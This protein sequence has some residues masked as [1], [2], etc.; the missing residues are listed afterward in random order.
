MAAF[1]R[2]NCPFENPLATTMR[3]PATALTSQPGPAETRLLTMSLRTHL[4]EDEYLRKV[5]LVAYLVTSVE[6]LLLFDLPRL[7]WALPPELN[8]E[9]LAGKTTTKLGEKLRAHAS[10][11]TDQV[12]AD[13][14]DAGGAALLE[15]GLQRNAVLH[16]RPA[17][18]DAGRTRLYRWRLPDAYFI[19]DDRLD[20]LA[21]R[22]DDLQV[23]L[24]ALRPPGTAE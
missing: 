7:A 22:I 4:P 5:G 13:Y 6:G 1:R 19:D 3:G 2:V 24:N 12:V 14:M 9:S 10:Q 20:Q 16:A 15:I 21:G 23:E 17:T 18:D 8:V 11:C